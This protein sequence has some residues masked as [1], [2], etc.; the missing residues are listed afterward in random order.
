MY[1]EHHKWKASL[2]LEL[3]PQPSNVNGE[4]GHDKTQ[5]FVPSRGY[6]PE[7]ISDCVLDMMWWKLQ[8]LLLWVPGTLMES[9]SYVQSFFLVSQA[10]CM[11]K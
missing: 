8:V 10:Y 11:K 1:C 4:T 2:A 7:D 9:H 6:D 5:T 3:E